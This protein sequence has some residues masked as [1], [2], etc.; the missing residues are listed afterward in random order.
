MENNITIKQYEAEEEIP[1]ELLLL[2]DPSKESIL[3]YL[4]EGVI[5]IARD[6]DIVTG[7]IVTII[8]SDEAEIMNISVKK[9]Y[10]NLGIGQKLLA[11][12]SHHLKN[13]G[14][15]KLCVGTGNSSIVP[16]YLY[17]KAGFRL[18]HIEKDYFLKK[19]KKPII[20][21]GI[22]CVDMIHMVKLM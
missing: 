5:F 16:F 15:R 10:Q 14:I 21:N 12:I 4:K 3:S 18:S 11:E 22:Q 7:I 1:L 19:Y 13:E 2:A 8:R 20:E 6:K 9:T 17:Q